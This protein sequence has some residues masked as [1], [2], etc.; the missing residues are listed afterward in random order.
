[1]T[2]DIAKD[3]RSDEDEDEDHVHQGNNFPEG[4]LRDPEDSEVEEALDEI[5]E[6]GLSDKWDM[7]YDQWHSPQSQLSST[8]AQI[9]PAE[10]DPASPH[11]PIQDS[12]MPEIATS[13]SR[14]IEPRD[15]HQF[16]LDGPVTWIGQKRKTQ[17]LQAILEVCTCGEAMTHKEISSSKSII[18]C[19]STECETGWVSQEIAQKQ[20]SKY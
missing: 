14:M 11:C 3:D 10:S 1:M 9:Q 13:S 4:V 8:P 16:V 6:Q 2:R 15:N 12:P 5:P 19:K 17:D 20:S 18:R 7:D